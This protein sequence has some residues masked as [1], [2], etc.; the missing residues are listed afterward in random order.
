M[1]FRGTEHY[2]QKEQLF[3]HAVAYCDADGVYQYRGLYYSRDVS[4]LCDRVDQ[5]QE[6]AE[7]ARVLLGGPNGEEHSW[8]RKDDWRALEAALT[9]LQTTEEVAR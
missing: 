9:A 8:V 2:R 5:L 6:V 1:T 7:A 4:E 3:T